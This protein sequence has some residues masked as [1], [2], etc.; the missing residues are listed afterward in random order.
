M[1][2]R[3]YL[4]QVAMLDRILEN[5]ELERLRLK[6]LASSIPSPG[7]GVRVRSSGPVDRLS[8]AVNSWVDMEQQLDGEIGVLLR[9]RQERVSLLQQLTDPREYGVLHQHYIQHMTLEQIAEATGKSYTWAAGLHR[10]ALRSAQSLLD[11]RPV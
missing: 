9:Q 6:T 7:A 2:I 1:D 4:G 5:K 10:Q 3:E 11:A 8:T